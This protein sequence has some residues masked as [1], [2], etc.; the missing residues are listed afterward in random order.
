[1]VH[2]KPFSKREKIESLSF[3][4]SFII[5]IG[6]TSRLFSEVIPFFNPT[7]Q[8]LQHSAIMNIQGFIANDL[9]SIKGFFN[10]WEGEYSPRN[11]NNIAM[12]EF[13]VDIGTKFCGYYVGYF[14][15]RNLLAIANRGFVDFYHALKNDTPF[16]TEQN[17]H[18]KLEM[19]G[20]QEHG[21][22]LSKNMFILN[23][24]EQKLMIGASAYLSYATDVQDGSLL[25]TGSISSDKT[26]SATATAD[27]YYLNNLLYD[28]DVK[29]TYGIGYGLHLG[30]LYINKEYGVDLHILANNLV[31]KSYWK[32]L[33]FSRVKVESNNQIINNHGHVEYNPTISGLELYRDYTQEITPKYHMD[34]KKHF[35]QE[36]DVTV[37]IDS[38]ENVTIPYITISKMLN[39][40][41]KV[42][43]LYETR[44]K[45]KGITF[46]GKNYTISLMSN[47]FSDT[48]AIAFSGNYIYHF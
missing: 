6:M 31:S 40:T 37:G 27:Y 43:L 42:E 48:S 15:T 47:G 20:I 44:F 7:A 34:I 26:Y 41:Q 30:L 18:L 5:I 29:N 24:D 33:P 12:E 45:S 16:D 46:Q 10:D 21:I 22:L 2:L 1:M 14:Y 38:I 3:L 17:Y 35:S 8:Y 25:G 11:K 9:V 19:N 36:I 39:K 23:N 28:L 13:R 32:H 4:K